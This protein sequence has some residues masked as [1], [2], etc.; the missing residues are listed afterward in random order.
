M[1]LADPARADNSK[2]HALLLQER[3]PRRSRQ[4]RIYVPY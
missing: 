4:K 3:H 2:F 1:D